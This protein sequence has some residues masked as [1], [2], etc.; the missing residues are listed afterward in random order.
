MKQAMRAA[1]VVTLLLFVGACG[2]RLGHIQQR[3]P[4]RTANF[5]GDH[6]GLA[7]CVQGRLHG[8]LQR[9]AFEDSIII[10]DSVKGEEQYGLTHYSVTITSTG[11]D[12]GTAEWRIVPPPV[13]KREHG[14]GGV[15]PGS[16][17]PPPRKDLTDAMVRKY[18]TPVEDCIAS[19]K[20][21]P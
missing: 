5:A 18:W 2:T 19:A 9:E 16:R 3:E 21:K 8:K 10:Y 11:S 1:A 14:R 17:L 6:V 13:E 4:I 20:G 12:Q 15:P 7:K